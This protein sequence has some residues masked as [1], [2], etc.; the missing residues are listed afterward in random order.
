VT[1]VEAQYADAHNLRARIHLHEHFSTNPYPYPR[2]VFDDYDFPAEA[3]VLEV[4]CGDGMIWRENLDRLPE[5]WRLT[6]TDSS[7]GMV[8]EARAVLGDRAR[9]AVA[10]V[11][12]LPF[13]EKSF[14]A[15]I[16][17]HMLFHVAERAQA[18]RQIRRVLRPGG[19]F[20]STTVG[21]DHLRELRELA[22]Q[23]PNSQFAQSRGRYSAETA[24]A[25]LAPFFEDVTVERYDSSLR[26]TEVEP[27]VHFVASRGGETAERLDRVRAHV[28]EAIASQGC[29]A[30]TTHTARIRCRKH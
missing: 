8:G 21:R 24:P 11:E 7:E 20:V 3:D 18:F 14:D 2:W 15:V 16:A 27:V 29:F 12:E 6:L 1:T 30:I 23:L 9:Y 28:A 5:G 10:R 17:N 25:E 4:G 13:E 26:V 22:P 19:T